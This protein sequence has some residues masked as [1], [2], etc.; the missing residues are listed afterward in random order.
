MSGVEGHGKEIITTIDRG[1]SAMQ[2]EVR[3]NDAG[4]IRPY[5][6]NDSDKIQMDEIKTIQKG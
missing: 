3:A 4:T 1:I 6:H 2:S 5:K